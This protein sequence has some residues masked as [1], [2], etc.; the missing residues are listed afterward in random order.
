[1][2]AYRP[3]VCIFCNASTR[4]R[5]R[6]TD[7]FLRTGGVR[8]GPAG[9]AIKHVREKKKVRHWPVSRL[10]FT[11]DNSRWWHAWYV[12]CYVVRE[13]IKGTSVPCQSFGSF[14]GYDSIPLIL[15]RPFSMRID[16]Q[17]S[18][19]FYLPN[20]NCNSEHECCLVLFWFLQRVVYKKKSSTDGIPYRSHVVA[21][22][23]PT[24]KRT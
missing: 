12:V 11:K 23:Q 18:Y 6:Y 1:M 20:Y 22:V 14:S 8:V 21:C 2:R 10:A 3:A 13:N 24:Q 9:G 15:A 17:D 5:L 16:G 7:K 4:T 19:Y